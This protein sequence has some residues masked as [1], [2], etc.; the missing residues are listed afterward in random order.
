MLLAFSVAL[1]S[2]QVASPCASTE[3]LVF[4]CSIK[5]KVAAVCAGPATGTPEWLQYRFGPGELQFPVEKDGSLRRFRRHTQPLI[6]GTSELLAFV[7]AGVTY[8]VFTQDGKDVGAGVT[9]RKTGGK[10]ITLMCTGDFKENWE[11]LD[12]T[13]A[14]GDTEAAITAERC[15]RAARATLS[16]LLTAARGQLDGMQQGELFE[17]TATACETWPVPGAECVAAGKWPCP[18]LTDEQV[19]SLEKSHREIIQP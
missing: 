12:G 13:V 19:K 5:K 14:K 2:G 10:L 17:A 18:Q 9:I 6:S 11:L 15:S 3:R 4:S 8:E 1:L 16:R 7:N